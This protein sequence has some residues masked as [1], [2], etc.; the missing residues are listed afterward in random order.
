MKTFTVVSENDT[1]T[2]VEAFTKED[3][4]RLQISWCPGSIQKICI[5]F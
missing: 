1:K 4:K 2:I 5:F 3:A